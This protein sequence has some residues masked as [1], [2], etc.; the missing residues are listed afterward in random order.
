MSLIFRFRFADLDH[1]VNEFKNLSSIHERVANF[2]RVHKTLPSSV[3]L[4]SD[5]SCT[6]PDDRVHDD[7]GVPVP[8]R[9]GTK[10]SR[11][12]CASDSE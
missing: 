8:V 11:D 4:D 10:R 6:T 7:A 5:G 1:D 9:Y 3:P 2:L 12:A